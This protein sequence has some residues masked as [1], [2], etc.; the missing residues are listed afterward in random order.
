MKV[1]ILRKPILALS[2]IFSQKNAIIAPNSMVYI[3]VSDRMDVSG[4]LT[5]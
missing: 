4:N 2:F 1:Y 3:R 5:G